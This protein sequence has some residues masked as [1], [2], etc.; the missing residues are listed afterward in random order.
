[1]TLSGDGFR[2]RRR[3]H[4]PLGRRH[5]STCP[6]T[7]ASSSRWRRSCRS[8]RCPCTVTRCRR[9]PTPSLCWPRPTARTGGSR[10][11]PSST[12]P[13]GGC[14]PASSG[15]FGGLNTHRKHWDG[16][17]NKSLDVVP[18]AA[19][20]L[21]AVGRSGSTPRQHPWSTSAA[22][23][24]ATPA[25]SPASTAAGCRGST[26]RRGRSGRGCRAATNE[27]LDARF[28][29]GQPLRP[30]GGADPRRPAQP[31]RG[32][33]RP[34]RDGSLM[35][36]LKPAGQD[37]VLRLASMALRRGGTL[38][39]EFRTVQDRGP[40]P[41]LPGP[42]LPLRRPRRAPARIESFGGLVERRE[43]GLGLATMDDEDPHVCRLV[44][45]W[46]GPTG[47]RDD[48]AVSTREDAR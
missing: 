4:R 23:T 15:W 16:F 39:L 27:G 32:A 9:P 26:T 12:T 24:T 38:F 7:P 13:L 42:R 36:S 30:P 44:A 10:T 47:S 25:G 22:A 43:E 29:A 6:P 18:T 28:R 20:V 45:R 17:Y 3:L 31:H 41:P 8:R 5:R 19:V 21:R 34:L 11:R 40:S 46:S 37:H 14:P 48:D 2:V 1:M 33:G 35:H